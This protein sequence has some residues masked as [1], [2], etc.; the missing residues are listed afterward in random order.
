MEGAGFERQSSDGIEITGCK[1]I[2][3]HG[4]RL[5]WQASLQI[6]SS[7]SASRAP[8]CVYS[9]SAAI[10]ACDKSFKWQFAQE[11]LLKMASTGTTPN[12]LLGIPLGYV[13]ISHIADYRALM[14]NNC[15]D[16]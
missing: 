13:L 5:Q 16:C 9:F 15:W 10:T 3:A 11:L 2:V 14:V 6:L 4:K 8:P 12:V 1:A 7:I